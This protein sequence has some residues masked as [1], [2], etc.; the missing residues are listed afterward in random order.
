[1]GKVGWSMFVMFVTKKV[2]M[3]PMIVLRRV[4][5]ELKCP[6]KQMASCGV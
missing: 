1:M 2:W 6:P 3:M 5:V 4:A